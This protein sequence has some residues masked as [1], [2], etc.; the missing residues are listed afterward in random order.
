MAEV[1]TI[2]S[3]AWAGVFVLIVVVFSLVKDFRIVR[4]H[5]TSVAKMLVQLFGLGFVIVGILYVQLAIGTAI[6]MGLTWVMIFA[7][8]VNAVITTGSRGKQIPHIHAI[9]CVGIVTGTFSVLLVLLIAG[10]AEYTPIGLIPFVGSIAGNVLN[11]NSQGLERIAAEFQAR[12]PEMETILTL[13]GTIRQ[14]TAIAERKTMQSVFIPTHDSMRNAGFFLPGAAVGLIITGMDP[15]EAMIFQSIMFLS[16]CGGMIISVT[17]V[18][19]LVVRQLVTPD[20]QI[21]YDLV[22]KL[23]PLDREHVKAFHVSKNGD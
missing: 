11:K 15:I 13:G 7:M 1:F 19:D 9:T 12:L 8:I 22:R 5:L 2:E 17:I 4:E 16:W 3:L 14:A 6:A 20:H 10:I 23:V 21:N 18:S